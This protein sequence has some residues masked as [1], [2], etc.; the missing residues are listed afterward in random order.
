MGAIYFVFPIEEE[1]A[2]WLTEEAIEFPKGMASRN[3]FLSEI[4]SALS[5]LDSFS[6]E[7]SDETLGEPWQANIEHEK[8]LENK[9][10][11]L[12]NIGALHK[13]Q[14]KIYFSSSWPEVILKILIKL[15]ETTGPLV[16]ICDSDWVPLVVE[17]AADANKLMEKWI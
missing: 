5:S 3:P 17:Q 11:A 6:V 15:T 9:G 2:A 1:M 13:S 8:D 10:W 4:K 7:F 16:V 12:M 14:N